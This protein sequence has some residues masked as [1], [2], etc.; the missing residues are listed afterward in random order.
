MLGQIRARR[1][2]PDLAILFNDCLEYMS[3]TEAYLSSLDLIERQ[4]TTTSFVDAIASI[5]DGYK[6]GS[7]VTSAA[8]K[9]GMSEDNA[10]NAGKLVGAANAA[11]NLYTKSQTRDANYRTAVSEQAQKLENKWNTTWAG[12]QAVSRRLTVKYRWGAGE[13][14]FDGFQSPQ[15]SDLIA[16]SPRD[17]FLKA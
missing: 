3:A 16:R 5:W 15:L 4:R 12:L 6:T 9:L 7:D 10:A 8:G 17:P 2:D 1:L 14:G 13:A 11:A